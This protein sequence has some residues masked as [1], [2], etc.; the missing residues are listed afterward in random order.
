M[1]LPQYTDYQKIQSM[2]PYAQ[3][4]AGR[5]MDL[6]RT[7]QQEKLAG[8]QEEV[9]RRQLANIFSEQ[10]NPQKI[11]EQ[12]L[13]NL[14]SQ[15]G[16]PAKKL[17]GEIAEKTGPQQMQA[18]IQDWA[19]KVSQGELD[20]MYRQGQHLAYKGKTQQE[21]DAGLAIMQMHPEFVKLKQQHSQRMELEKFQQAEQ[22]KRTGMTIAGQKDRAAAT[23]AGKGGGTLADRLAAAKT[24]FHK[25]NVFAGE[26]ARAEAAGDV[27][28]MQYYLEQA[29]IARQ[30]DI[31][32]RQ[33]A[34]MAALQ[35][36]ID[37]EAL[38]KEG[39]LRYR[40]DVEEGKAPPPAAKKPA[41][42]E[43]R[44]VR[45]KS[46]DGKTGT[47]PESQLQDAVRAGYVR[48]Q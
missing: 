33:A 40:K 16:L 35:G 36:K 32:A 45:V 12:R 30:E 42:P 48:V 22:T 39:V 11:E 31:A 29:E 23:A 24:P 38:Q 6:A 9:K 3:V 15:Y 7:F 27:E 8:E 26:A 18:A 10:N 14:E 25:S 20:D 19:G 34:A 5:Q 44:R 4:L 28:R 17:A 13:K 43:Q 21:K 46:P 1:E 47:I 41:P 37:I 2:D